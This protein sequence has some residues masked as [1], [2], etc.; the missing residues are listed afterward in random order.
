MRASYNPVASRQFQGET[1][2]ALSTF[3]TEP[4]NQGIQEYQVEVCA[5][6]AVGRLLSESR[7][8]GTEASFELGA[9]LQIV[10]ES[11]LDFAG[12][13]RSLSLKKIQTL[14]KNQDRLDAVALLI[15]QGLLDSAGKVC[16]PQR[17][18]QGWVE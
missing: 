16:V 9:G 7:S 18:R 14:R 8:Y 1:S 2:L 4:G 17:Y 10:D 12:D 11:N 13:V 5:F 3:R 6:A 15:D